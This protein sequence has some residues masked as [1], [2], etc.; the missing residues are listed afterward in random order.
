MLRFEVPI[1][2]LRL[3]NPV[4]F[5]TSS[6]S[7]GPFPIARSLALGHRVVQAM[8][9]GEVEGV[10]DAAR[11]MGVSHAR[12]S[13]LVALTF[14]SPKLQAELLLGTEV[15]LGF[16]AYL[17]IAR[18]EGWAAQEALAEEARSAQRLWGESSRIGSRKPNGG[19]IC[20]PNGSRKGEKPRGKGGRVAAPSALRSRAK[21]AASRSGA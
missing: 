10:K 8:E 2:R 19:L 1:L 9:A 7:R 16:H 13:T 6:S 17:R 18:V 15:P 21:S 12:V 4:V 3:G 5:A 11:R 20:G 14:L